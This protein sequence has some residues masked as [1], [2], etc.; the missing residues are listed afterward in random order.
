M[1]FT[2]FYY[3]AQDEKIHEYQTETHH[4]LH[5]EPSNTLF[6]TLIGSN[7]IKLIEKLVH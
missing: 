4:E 5:N 3:K 6:V 1:R 7:E 2:V